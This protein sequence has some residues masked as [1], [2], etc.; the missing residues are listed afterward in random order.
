[1]NALFQFTFI[2]YFEFAQFLIKNIVDNYENLN[3]T[4]NEKS[5]N[6]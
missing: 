2:P 6:K 5:L 3:S 1:M 4:P